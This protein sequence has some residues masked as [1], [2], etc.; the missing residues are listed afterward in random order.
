MTTGW[1]YGVIW[2]VIRGVI[3]GTASSDSCTSLEGGMG[4][5]M[6]SYEGYGGTKRGF[7][8]CNYVV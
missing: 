1:R 4:G 2:E 8:G 5:D 7:M 6:G 3:W